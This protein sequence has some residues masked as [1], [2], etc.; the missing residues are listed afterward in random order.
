MILTDS[1]SSNYAPCPAGS[2]LARCTRLLDLGS[3][4]SDYQGEVKTARKLL[5]SFEVLDQDTRRDDGEPYV[6]S[7]RYTTSL[8]EKSGL[9]KDLAGW[10]GRDFSAQELKGFDVRDI[11]GK[12]AF[13]SV[14]HTVKGD[15]TYSN[16]AGLM[17]PP[18]GLVGAAATEPL[19]YWSMADPEPDWRAFELLHLK[20]QEQIATSPEFARLRRP[21][22][23][24]LN[25]PP[26][27]AFADLPDEVDF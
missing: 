16:L 25:E 8:H 26:P 19:L 9:R 23:V 1:G 2:Y 27:H 18:K 20:L 21:S 14:I 11:L 22:V 4:T 15:R 17:R 24:S 5:I 6:L 3:Q 13:I 7:K 12:S 10:R